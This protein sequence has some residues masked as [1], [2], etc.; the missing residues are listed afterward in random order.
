M[1]I[2]DRVPSKGHWWWDTAVANDGGT[3]NDER[4]RK[5]FA[6]AF[7]SQDDCPVGYEHV[8]TNVDAVLGSCGF[9]VEQQV[10]PFRTSRVALV[11]E[12]SLRTQNV[13]RL[14]VE[15]G[16]FDTVDGDSISDATRICRPD[17][18]WVPCEATGRGPGTSGPMRQ[19]VESA[20]HVVY[21]P[22]ALG[23]ATYLANQ[24]H[25]TGHARAPISNDDD[26]SW[27]AARDK[28]ENLVLVGG[29]S[30]AAQRALNETAAPLGL[31]RDGVSVGECYFSGDLG[32]ASLLP[33]RDGRLTLLIAATSD[34][35]L[36]TTVELLATPT[37]PPMARQPFSNALPDVVV[38]AARQA[39][40]FGPGG[41]RL[42][43]F[44]DHD[45]S[46]AHQASY[47]EE[48]RHVANVCV[49]YK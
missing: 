9:R 44:W 12:R 19:V 31:R 17:L 6:E 4:L 27:D 15:A 39:R 24:F 34:E 8:T 10:V 40:R 14:A 42:A 37:I 3:V 32:V 38:L 18:A 2:R 28:G 16:Q 7:V 45:W 41:F 26:F 33:L 30:D 21:E 43:G 11:A 1:C 48:C 36:D 35:A 25:L 22:G 23:L 29:D 46:F 47:A 5:F 20:F 13:R 49:Y